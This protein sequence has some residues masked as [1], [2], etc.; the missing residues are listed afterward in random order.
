MIPKEVLKRLRRIEIT[1][2]RLANDQLVGSYASVF[3][4]RGLA[5]DEVRMYQPGD[6][7]R[8]IDWNVTARTSTPH[9]KVFREEREMTVMLLVDMS[10]SQAF[11]TQGMLKRELVAEV[12]AV[13]AFSAT[14]NNDR[15]GLLLF[16]DNVER[17]VPPRKGAR[18]VMR[19]VAETLQFQP[20]GHGTNLAR[21][22]DTLGHLA[23]RR[24]VTFV[25][26]DFLGD[27]YE[28]SLRVAAARHDIVPVTVS[29][30][31]EDELVDVGLA[32]CEDLE[33]GELIPVDTADPAVR[34]AYRRQ[35]EQ[36]KAARDG[37]FRRLGLDAISVRTDRP[38]ITALAEFFRRRARRMHG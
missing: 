26:S 15:V 36:Q 20:K 18:H 27:D 33:T 34:A 25:V 29:D 35:V 21:A 13:L 2:A 28:H 31:R 23:R 32:W 3:K 11:G 9:V 7:V 37:L 38:Y 19:V 24:A 12:S 16:T 4:G 8:F 1:T 5:F 6:D 10:G 22:L 30:P 14:K 17:I